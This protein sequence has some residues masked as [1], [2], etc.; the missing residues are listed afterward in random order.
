MNR[1]EYEL[2]AGYLRRYV[3]ANKGNQYEDISRQFALNMADLLEA[4][5]V[6]FN[7]DRFL[8]ACGIEQDNV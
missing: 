8:K 6:N 1:K 7:K 3:E 4:E 5:Y 2:L